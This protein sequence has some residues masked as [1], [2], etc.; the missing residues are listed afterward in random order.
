MSYSNIKET[1][2]KAIKG[3]KLNPVEESIAIEEFVQIRRTINLNNR[4]LN[5]EKIKDFVDNCIKDILENKQIQFIFADGVKSF[6][7]YMELYTH[8]NSFEYRELKAG[9]YI[10][11]LKADIRDII[12]IERNSFND[13][14]SLDSLNRIGNNLLETLKIPQDILLIKEA[15]KDLIEEQKDELKER[16]TIIGKIQNYVYDSYKKYLFN[17]DIDF[18]QQPELIFIDNSTKNIVLNGFVV[19]YNIHEANRNI[20]INVLMNDRHF[21]NSLN[22]LLD[23]Y[24]K[25]DEKNEYLNSAFILKSFDHVVKHSSFITFLSDIKNDLEA[26]IETLSDNGQNFSSEQDRLNT[27][28]NLTEHPQIRR[29]FNSHRK[30]NQNP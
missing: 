18:F 27:I 28:N 6:N 21:D 17:S 15:L 11:K 25:L 10:E 9:I 23:V 20:V 26:Q 12:S 8:S 3:M 5:Q 22:E 1:L 24:S 16:V 7:E 30:N 13:R 29:S 19:D 14:N 4:D 2:E